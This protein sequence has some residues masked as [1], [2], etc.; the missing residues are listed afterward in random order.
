LKMALRLIHVPA[1][2]SDRNRTIDRPLCPLHK[3]GPDHI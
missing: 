2:A 1:D 3:S